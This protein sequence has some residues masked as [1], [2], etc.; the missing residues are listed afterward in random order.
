MPLIRNDMINSQIFT[1][2]ILPKMG[3][4]EDFSLRVQGPDP[5]TD[6][7]VPI[8]ISGTALA[9]WNNPNSIDA[10]QQL[11]AAIFDKIG[12]ASKPPEEGYWFDSYN[13]GE[14]L[15]DTIHKIA[16]SDTSPFIKNASKSL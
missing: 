16:N 14:S 12:T 2:T 5:S 3:D 4:R 15:Q 13:S 8:S 6:F 1:A 7:Q 11:G 9:I 10:A